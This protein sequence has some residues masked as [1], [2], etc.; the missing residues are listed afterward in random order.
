MKQDPDCIFCKIVAGDNPSTKVYEDEHTLA[1]LDI[2]PIVKGHTLVIPK[3]HHDL[4]TDT[5]DETLE[6]VIVQIDV[7]RRTTRLLQRFHIHRKAVI[8]AGNLDA[9]G[10][11]IQHGQ[12]RP[13]VPETQFVRLRPQSQRQHLMP[14]A[15][16]ED[17]K[18]PH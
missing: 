1:F 6:R 3:D 8:L 5:P 9:A 13:V 7:R 18:L 16:A 14:Q 15:N 12:V 11:P 2:G 10:L 17:R 4:L